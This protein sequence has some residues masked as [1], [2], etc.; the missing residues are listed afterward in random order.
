M[1]LVLGVAAIGAAVFVLATWLR[2]VAAT[3][4]AVAQ[5]HAATLDAAAQAA[6]LAQMPGVSPQLAIEV[7][8]PPAVEARAEA[9]PCPV[10]DGPCHVEAHVVEVHDAQRLR[11]AQVR[12]GRCGARRSLYF[13]LRVTPQL[14]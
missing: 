12:C 1:Q 11:V 8:S 3:D 13:R 5:K 10:C 9:M 4:D 14:N 2:R 7:V 6:Q